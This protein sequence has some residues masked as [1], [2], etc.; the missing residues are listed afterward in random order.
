MKCLQG[1]LANYPEKC[2]Q[3]QLRIVWSQIHEH[4]QRWWGGQS[5][6]H[7]R[8]ATPLVSENLQPSVLVLF[9][10]IVFVAR[11]YDTHFLVAARTGFI[12]AVSKR[13]HCSQWQ[14]YGAG[15]AEGG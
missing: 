11:Y 6:Y 15:G 4:T 8:S 12:P 14:Y 3:I 9:F 13:T 2:G 10:G 1:K 5:L 7:T